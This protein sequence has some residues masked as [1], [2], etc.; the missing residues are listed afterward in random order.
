MHGSLPA[1]FLHTPSNVSVCCLVRHTGGISIFSLTVM[2]AQHN[3]S[4]LVMV[5]DGATDLEARQEGGADL[6]IG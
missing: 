1:Y 5:G 2:Q 6:F 3:Y 4:P